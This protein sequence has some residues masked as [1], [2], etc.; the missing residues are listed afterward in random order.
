MER[1]VAEGKIRAAVLRLMRLA[2]VDAEHLPMPTLAAS[3]CWK[4]LLVVFATHAIPKQDQIPS[5][6]NDHTLTQANAVYTWA[7]VGKTAAE[8][9]SSTRSQHLQ[10]LAR[11]FTPAVSLLALIY[12]LHHSLIAEASVATIFRAEEGTGSHAA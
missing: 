11:E 4:V 2:G 8:P 3:C 10:Q 7:D 5:N 9:E 1:L 12:T 6:M